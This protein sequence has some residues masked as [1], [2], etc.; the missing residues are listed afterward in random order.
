M[1]VQSKRVDDIFQTK[2]TGQEAGGSHFDAK[3]SFTML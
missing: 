2:P 3:T 1:S